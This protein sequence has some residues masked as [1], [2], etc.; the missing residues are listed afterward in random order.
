VV[1]DG[2]ENEFVMCAEHLHRLLNELSMTPAVVVGGSGGLVISLALASAYPQDV[3]ALMIDSPPSDNPQLLQGLADMRYLDL[4]QK[5]ADGGMQ[6]AYDW[7]NTLRSE[8]EYPGRF[9]LMKWVAECVKYPSNRESFLSFDPGVFEET[10]RRWARSF[11]SDQ[12]FKAGLTDTEVEQITCPAFVM[13]GFYDDL[14]P[15]HTAEKL[16]SL[17]PQS[18]FRTWSECF[19]AHEINEMKAWAAAGQFQAIRARVS[20]I[21]DRFLNRL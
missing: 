8:P 3:R 5:A 11:A 13:P 20:P 14:H 9:E 12:F 1:A 10:C 21:Q 18:E 16:H 7:L 17:L 4:A 2:S 6:A 19:S 15:Q